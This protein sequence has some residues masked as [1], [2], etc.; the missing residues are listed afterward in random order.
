[1]KGPGITRRLHLSDFS[2]IVAMLI[3]LM[4]GSTCLLMAQAFNI[5]QLS[6]ETS[7]NPTAISFGPDKRLYVLEVDGRVK[8]YTIAR[9]A[10][11]TYNVTATETVSL[12][13][14]IQ[15]HN[16]NGTVH[17]TVRRQATGMY[18][19]GTTETPVLYISSSDYREGGGYEFG[20]DT[21]LDTNSGIISRLTK[22]GGS[23]TRLD[24]VRG[25]PRSEE[26]HATNGLFL[27]VSANMLYV[28]QGGNTNGGAPARAFAY[29]CEYALSGAVLII[30]LNMLDTMSVKTD[31]SSGASYVYDLPTL[32]DPSR[33]NAN[34]IDDPTD[35]D[36]DGVD[37][38]DPF[39][40]NDGLNQAKLVP[41]GPVQIHAAGFRNIYDLVMTDLGYLYGWDNG[42]NPIWGGYPINEGFGTANN[43]YLASE[44]GSGT[45]NNM[46]CLHKITSTG[47]YAGH[48]NPIRGNP[49]SA[50]L[51]T[52]GT[53]GVFRTEY[54]PGDPATS[55]PF[56][57]PPVS[58][59]DPIQGDFQIAGVENT[60]MHSIFKN[61]MDGI[62][63]YK[64]SNFGGIMQGD[65]LT[66]GF[67]SQ[68]LYRIRLDS[69]GNLVSPDSVTVIASNLEGRSID[70]CTVGDEPPFPGSIWVI[71]Q[72]SGGPIYVLEPADFFVCTGADSYAIDEDSDV[73]TNADEY[74]NGTNPC[75]AADRPSDFDLTL[76]G[77]FLVSNLNDPDDDDDGIPDSTDYFVW[78]PANGLSTSIPLEYPLLNGNPGTGFYGLG[79][80]GLMMNGTSD[81]L[82]LWRNETNSS[83]SIV[84]GGAAG[85]LTI[86]PVDTGDAFSSLNHQHNGFQFGIA[87][88][89]L[90][91][92]F[93][94]DGMILGPVFPDTAIDFQSIGIMRFLTSL[95]TTPSAA[96]T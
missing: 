51:Y 18:V 16:D 68:K 48:A 4:T 31:T 9:T 30:D 40:G 12:A 65:L 91:D 95:P 37:I 14:Q 73:Y 42:P 76:I 39:G 8:I 87:V 49:D 82:E 90:T 60:F 10:P 19:T 17:T 79:F 89:S 15:N 63:E 29:L 34:G 27:D 2:C 96:C 47:Y 52:Y 3:V 43:S 33:I 28:A 58:V 84:A 69:M 23:W 25:L 21:N 71:G 26:N 24:L 81:Y 67:V 83:T 88:D 20:T 59:A 77:G 35:D 93:S 61:S 92:P 44:P 11:N 13:M 22:N 94:Y 7:L 57:W 32:D 46:D 5:S 66:A 78:D 54:L 6:G 55:L 74:D 86:A 80:T 38:H 1:M 70:V 41:G 53:A 45:M 36:Y 85:L 56:D 62:C 50:G 75:N 64:A 72:I